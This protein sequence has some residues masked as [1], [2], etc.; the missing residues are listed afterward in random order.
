M[1]LAA[2]VPAGAGSGLNRSLV[3][4]GFA[5][6]VFVTNAGDARLFVVE[7]DGLIKIVENGTTKTTF[8]DLTT[9]T[10]QSGERGLLGLA[11]HPDYASNGLLYV[12]YTRISDGDLVLAEYERSTGDPDKA[13]LASERVVLTIEHSSAGNHNGGTIM[14]K[15][16]NLFW[17]TGD[18]GNTPNAAQDL[19]SLLGK[20]LRINPMDPDGVGGADYSISSRNPYVGV[21]GRDEIW[22][23]GLRNPY[24]CSIDPKTRD[25][26]CGDVGQNRWEEVNHKGNAKGRNFGWPLL[27]GNHHY[28]S[29]DP[30]SSG[31][32][33]RP[34]LAYPHEAGA[35]DNNTVV[36]GYVARR[37]GQPLT[38]KY[39]F[40]DFGSG[41]V[42]AIRAGFRRGD[43]LPAPLENT[44]HTISSFGVDNLGRVYLVDYGG[45]VWRLTDT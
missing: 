7:Q 28:P 43:D 16:N 39:I 4:N 24:R 44:N 5:S 34:I 18:G 11:F 20:I 42:W 41:R 8:L 35:E 26:W 17:T 36:G 40:G 2:P 37:P 38:G 6:P 12:I 13:D 10:D 25:L 27:E 30:C 21:A 33:T 1:L 14:F 45:S 29:G 15:G 23:R 31:C 3:E 32:K 19:N 22:A 9:K